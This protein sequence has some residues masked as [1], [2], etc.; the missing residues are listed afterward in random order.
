LWEKEGAIAA[1]GK[2]IEDIQVKKTDVAHDVQR[3]EKANTNLVSECPSMS[4][5]MVSIS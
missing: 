4:V 2:L 3:I 1:S 5:S